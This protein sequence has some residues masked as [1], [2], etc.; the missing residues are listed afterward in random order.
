MLLVSRDTHIKDRETKDPGQIFLSN[1]S[2]GQNLSTIPVQAELFCSIS[3]NLK[4]LDTSTLSSLLYHAEPFW[5]PYR[6]W[7]QGPE[8]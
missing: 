5:P 7:N 1:R 8:A 3:V 6:P 2:H 4:A